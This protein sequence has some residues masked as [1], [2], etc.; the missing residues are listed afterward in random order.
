MLKDRIAE[1]KALRD[2]AR[3]DTERDEGAIERLG[4]TIAAQS[5]RAFAGTAR[6]RMRIEGVAT[7]AIIFAR[8]PNA[9]KSTRKNFASSGRKANCCAHSSPLQPQ[10]R[11]VLA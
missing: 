2:Q 8:S 6:R 1:L 5:I 9:S 10:K 7:G 4:P 3:A 11:Q